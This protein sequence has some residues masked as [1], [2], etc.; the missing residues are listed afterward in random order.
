LKKILAIGIILVMATM[1]GDIATKECEEYGDTT[2]IPLNSLNSTDKIQTFTF[3]GTPKEIGWQYGLQF[4]DAIHENVRLYWEIARNQGYERRNILKIVK[5]REKTIKEI[6]PHLLTELKAMAEASNVSYD[7]ILSLNLFTE[8]INNGNKEDCTSWIAT[9]N[10]T[11]NG[12]SIF[13]KN[14][15]G[16]RDIQV[17]VRIIPEEGYP[18]CALVTAGRNGIAAGINELGLAAGNNGISTFA[19]NPFGVDNFVVNRL[20]LERCHSVDSAYDMLKNMVEKHR[21]RGGSIIFVVDKE[22]GAIIEVT[23]FTLSS[24]EESIII[25]DVG[26]RSNHFVRLKNYNLNLKKPTSLFKPS[27]H[28]LKRYDAAKQFLEDRKGNVSIYDCNKLSRHQYVDENGVISEHEG[29]VCNYPEDGENGPSTLL[30]VTFQV[31]KSYPNELS[32]MWVALG[33]PSNTLYVP[34]HLISTEI[35]E[36]YLNGD[37]W[38]A[39]ECVRREK[40]PPLDVLKSYLLELEKKE[41]VTSSEI[42]NISYDYLKEGEVENAI[43]LLT[44]FDLSEG[45]W[46]YKEMKSKYTGVSLPVILSISDLIYYE[47]EN[48]LSI[49]VYNHGYGNASNVTISLYT[50][51]LPIGDTTVSI[52]QRTSKEFK[53]ELKD[54][55]ENNFD[56]S[57]TIDIKVKLSWDEMEASYDLSAR[58]LVGAKS[59]L[60]TPA[61][62][63]LI[64]IIYFALIYV[65]I[66]KKIRSK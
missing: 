3:H 25:D 10:A 29:S 64:V 48:A 49:E 33:L 4:K 45:R 56:V 8:V 13:H 35:C 27:E 15:D 2:F 16:S 37:S 30:G 34:I 19:I 57:Q 14:R 26:C 39:S 28:T 31:N 59:I 42:K 11:F 46:A 18:F 38:G 60:D 51:D 54:P 24:Y 12:N 40:L 61:F 23:G 47:G 36:T 44:S 9:G 65:Y 62:E 66:F 53:I 5:N 22:K 32:V 58:T 55:D 7:D 50:I 63:L 17:I 43:S 1:T 20:I 52:P 6:A 21:I 41:F